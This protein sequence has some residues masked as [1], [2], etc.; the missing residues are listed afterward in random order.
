MKGKKLLG[1]IVTLGLVVVFGIWS[2]KWVSYRLSHAI[3]NA[4]FVESDSLINL[5]Y[6]R[7]AGRIEKLYKK[8]GDKVSKGDVLAKLEDT[9]IRI[10]LKELDSEIE[11]L[12]KNIEALDIRAKTLREELSKR[13][14]QLETEIKALERRIEALK[15]KVAQL[16]KDRERFKELMEKGVVPSKKYEDIDTA[17][18]A[19]QK[20]LDSYR[21]K[22]LSL[23]KEKDI[24][25]TKVKQVEEIEKRRQALKDK[26]KALLAKR[27]DLLRMI[28]ET[29][30]RSPID[31]YVVK[32]YVSEGEVVRQ[33]QSIYSVY[34]PEDTYIL[35]LLE[36]TKLEGV[37][38]GAKAIV[39]IDAYPE[40]RFEG[41]VEHINMSTASKFAIIPRDITAG[42]F[43]KVAQRIPVRIEITKGD[44]SLLRVGMGGEVAIEKTR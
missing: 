10:K 41:V 39:K 26:E 44:R 1:L 38:E 7:V 29:K 36:E 35:V 6:K 32:R 28:E 34:N 9:D 24:L 4:V 31:G 20:E 30:L 19:N 12:R 37:K 43:T 2:I 16:K 3:T 15:T 17:L 25:T 21:F 23:K 8:E 14:D 18:Q 33:G 40:V 13:K 42:E 11:S 27:E 5:S 22:I